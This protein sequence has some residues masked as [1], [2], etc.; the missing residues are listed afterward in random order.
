MRTKTKWFKKDK[1]RSLEEIASHLAFTIWQ[2]CVLRLKN[3]EG[4]GFYINTPERT[5]K[6]MAEFMVFFAHLADRLAY[7]KLDGGQRQRLV[8]HMAINLR[9]MII[10]N[11]ADSKIAGEHGQVF[12]DTLNQR[13]QDYAEF[14]FIDDEPSYSFYRVLGHHVYNALED[15]YNQ[16]VIEQ[17]IE[18]EGPQGA[19]KLLSTARTFLEGSIVEEKPAQE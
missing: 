12:I 6:V 18:I 3:M 4:Q 19:Q 14:G 9:D 17:V 5:L 1:P 2:V 15:G 11:Y 13:F 10:D 16:G 7:D 8:S